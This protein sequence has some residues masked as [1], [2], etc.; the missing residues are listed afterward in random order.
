MATLNLTE[1]SN[2]RLVGGGPAQIGQLP[3][4]AVQEITF[5]VS[6]QSNAFNAKTTYVRLVSSIDCRVAVGA[7][8][9]AVATGLLLKANV[10]EY[11]GVAAGYKLAAYDG[12]S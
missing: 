8:P 5:T 7:N 6:T 1:L 4:E 2:L 11:F 12:V 3:E 10:I 9:T